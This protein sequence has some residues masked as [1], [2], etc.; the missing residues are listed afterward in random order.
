R[1]EYELSRLGIPTSW[2]NRGPSSPRRGNI[3]SLSL[4]ERAGVRAGISVRPTS[5]NCLI[6][7]DESAVP[8]FLLSA[9]RISA[10]WFRQQ[11]DNDRDQ[12]GDDQ[13]QN[14]PEQPAA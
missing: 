8:S 14:A 2:K 13:G 10:R 5:M 11:F 9:A 1:Y 3:F 4:G 6:K 7:R 12:P